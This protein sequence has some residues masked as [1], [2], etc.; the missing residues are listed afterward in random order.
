MQLMQ[1]DSLAR[2]Y[3]ITIINRGW[4]L[5]ITLAPMLGAG[6]ETSSPH[7]RNLSEDLTQKV[8]TKE[9]LCLSESWVL[10]HTQRALPVF[11]PPPSSLDY[12]GC[13]L[14]QEESRTFAAELG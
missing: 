1:L 2:V 13:H 7:G 12:R 14:P 3:K 9:V 5:S 8:R 10:H 11:I 6:L 4:I